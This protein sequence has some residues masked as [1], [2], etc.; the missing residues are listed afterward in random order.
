MEV[1]STDSYKLRLS[2]GGGENSLTKAV[3]ITA[4]CRC[5]IPPFYIVPEMFG[6]FLGGIK[7]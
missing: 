1:L 3:S 5:R 6:D 7:Q 4:L 2:L